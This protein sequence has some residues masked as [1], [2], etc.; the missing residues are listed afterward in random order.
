LGNRKII[1]GKL[2]EEVARM[3]REKIGVK[4]NQLTKEQADRIGVPVEGRYKRGNN[5]H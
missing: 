1:C 2:D 4:L 3:H 5:R